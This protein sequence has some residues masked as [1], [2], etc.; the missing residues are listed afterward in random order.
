MNGSRNGKP[1]SDGI[2]A[3]VDYLPWHNIRL[4]LQY[5][6]YDMFNGAVTSYDGFGRNASQNNTVYLLAW[7]NF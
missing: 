4:S 5:V 2:I 6:M 1:D 7:L 3:E